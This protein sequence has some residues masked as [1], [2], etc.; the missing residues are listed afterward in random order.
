M[1]ATIKVGLDEISTLKKADFHNP[2]D[3]L[4]GNLSSSQ[5][6][7]SQCT[8]AS[9]GD[10]QAFSRQYLADNSGLQLGCIVEVFLA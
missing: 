2:S 1:R 8:S 3:C 4:V 5:D 6:L 10:S 9:L 7:Q